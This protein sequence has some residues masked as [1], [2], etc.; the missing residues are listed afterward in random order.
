MVCRPVSC[1]E[2]PF[3]VPCCSFSWPLLS[4][5]P[6]LHACSSSEAPSP[7]ESAESS[8]IQ[9]LPSLTRRWCRLP[10]SVTDGIR[11]FLENCPWRC[12]TKD[13]SSLLGQLSLLEISFSG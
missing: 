4:L 9:R 12:I 13:C 6:A 7:C 10:H 1:P 3:T 2:F 11:S 5:P 8:E